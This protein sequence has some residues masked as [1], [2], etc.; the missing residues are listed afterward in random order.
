MKYILKKEL[1]LS[2]S[3]LSYLFILFGLMFFIPGYPILCGVFFV[4]LGIFQ[5]FQNAR[6]ANDIIFSALLPIAKKDVVKGKFIFSCFT[7]LCS[8]I[9]MSIA[10]ALRMTVLQNADVYRS[11]ALMNANPFALGMALLIFGIFNLIFIGGFFKTAYKFGWPF[12]THII[13]TFVMIGIGEA[14][15]HIPGLEA[16]N[17]FG[18]ECFR[19]QFC[20]LALGA[21]AY[22]ALT[23]LSYQCACR[24][25]ER[26]DL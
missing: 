16:L 19:L 24:N 1:T 23:L 13:L 17:A 8:I 15:Y 20:L 26:I 11:N 6:E 5:S 25:F 3:I 10:T 2:T 9:L 18:F 4:T 7:E 22:I 21:V 14:L 12:V